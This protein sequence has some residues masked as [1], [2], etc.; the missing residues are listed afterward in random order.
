MLIDLKNLSAEDAHSVK[1][2]ERL[3]TFALQLADAVLVME[4]GD[5]KE[6]DEMFDLA[7]GRNYIFLKAYE[8]F[9]RVYSMASAALEATRS[10]FR[11]QP[12][13]EALTTEQQ[14][15]DAEA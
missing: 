11:R 10:D 1:L 3:A 6:A 9:D 12:R 13:S 8:G 14:G 4:C 15:E 2:K 7:V 5:E